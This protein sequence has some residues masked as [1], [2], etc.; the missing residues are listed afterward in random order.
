ME[1]DPLNG[2]EREDATHHPLK[3]DLVRSGTNYIQD[4]KE[5]GESGLEPRRMII[6]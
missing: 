6:L 1:W 4:A 3:R 2:E 5:G